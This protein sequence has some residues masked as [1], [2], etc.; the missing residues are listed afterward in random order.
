MKTE[1]IV[2]GLNRHIEAKREENG[3]KTTGHLI[4]HKEVEPHSSFRAYKIYKYTLWFVKD[5]KSH[6]V[7]TLQHSAKVLNGQEEDVI[8]EI[9]IIFSEMIFNWMHSSF[10][11]KIIKGEY[12][13][14]SE[15]SN[16]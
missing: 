1:D 15:D 9:N 10:Y 6:R 13:G 5:K 16:E 2:E 12:N 3:I 11:E 4:L 14:V 8:R 7:L